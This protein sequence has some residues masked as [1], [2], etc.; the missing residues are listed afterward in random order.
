MIS[1]CPNFPEPKISNGKGGTRYPTAKEWID[2]A[3]RIPG[4]GSPHSNPTVGDVVSD[5]VHM[6][7]KS[8]VGVIQA[9]SPPLSGGIYD[10]PPEKFNPG[11]GR[12]PR[13]R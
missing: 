9:P 13:I 3:I 6:G 5:G 8:P 2:P 10:A 7:I 1:K 11:I 12:S 4:F